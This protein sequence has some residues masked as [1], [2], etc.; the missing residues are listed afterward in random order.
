MHRLL[1]VEVSFT[2]L[3]FFPF[4]ESKTVRDFRYCLE[5]L[6]LGKPPKGLNNRNTIAIYMPPRYA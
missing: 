5:K 1:I 6:Y 3:V 4:M 2:L